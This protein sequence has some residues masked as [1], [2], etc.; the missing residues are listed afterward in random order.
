MAK[1]PGEVPGHLRDPHAAEQQM[2]ALRQTAIK[3]A[4]GGPKRLGRIALPCPMCRGVERRYRKYCLV[5]RGRGLVRFRQD[6]RNGRKLGG[7]SGY[8]GAA[9]EPGRITRE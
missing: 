8:P 9:D 3:I 6:R 1:M 7:A 4:Q 5:C 2:M